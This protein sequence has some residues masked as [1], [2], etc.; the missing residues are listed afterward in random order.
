[1]IKGQGSAIRFYNSSKSADDF[2]KLSILS[3]SFENVTASNASGSAIDV[4]INSEI[5][6]DDS[7]FNNNGKTGRAISQSLNYRSATNHSGKME[8]NNSSFKNFVTSDSGGAVAVNYTEVD[9][10]VT[11]NG[12]TF[13]GNKTTTPGGPGGA[14]QVRNHSKSK[15]VNLMI[16]GTQFNDNVSELSQGGA[17]YADELSNVSFSDVQ[18]SNNA[19]HTQGGAVVM[20]N[21]WDTIKGTF[22]VT[23]TNNSFIGNKVT[24]EESLS[25]VGGAMLIVGA[26]D[27]DIENTLFES[28]SSGADGGAI[29]V[30]GNSGPEGIYLFN[31]SNSQFKK[32]SSSTAQG[33]ALSIQG[34]L[35]AQISNVEFS[36]NSAI[37]G[38]AIFV[39]QP[40]DK[41]DNPKLTVTN[42]QF[43][44][45]TATMYDGGAVSLQTYYNYDATF[46]NNTFD[47]NTADKGEG[48]AIFSWLI[49]KSTSEIVKQNITVSGSTL[50]KNIA[51]QG[52]VIS[53]VVYN[54]EVEANKNHAIDIT[55][56]DS[57]ISD[58]TSNTYGG[59]IF[60]HNNASLQASNNAFSKNTAKESGGAVQFQSTPDFENS[61]N[62]SDS[63]FESNKAGKNGGSISIDVNGDITA[64]TKDADYNKYFA[65]TVITRT[66]FTDN[67]AGNGAFI[68]DAEKYPLLAELAKTNLTDIDSLSSPFLVSHNVAYN[69]HDIN[70]MSDKVVKDVTV[71]YESNGGSTV[72]DETVAYNSVFTKP[73]NPTLADHTF[74]GWFIDN[75]LTKAYDFNTPATKDI[76]LYAKWGKIPAD[77]DSGDPT[78]G[79]KTPSKP[80]LKKVLP[81][82]GEQNTINFTLVGFVLLVTVGIFYWYKRKRT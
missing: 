10:N 81:K 47:S 78:T 8:I 42:S 27:T 70:F 14:L 22:K 21:L 26:I 33:G 15:T 1:M 77:P 20:A 54:K 35:D 52:G 66:S 49:P 60:V 55:V 82:T 73:E 68:L 58:N 76:T 44:S 59:G 30:S 2:V 13:E 61:M 19:A 53:T 24:D 25:A 50:Q 79:T 51:N 67:T 5:K 11:I 31:V 36:E 62:I 45:N 72:P 71:K 46:E 43:N 3:S 57:I 40:S 7:T 80:A 28:N 69:N 9:G 18:F 6:V 56:N 74:E 39:F 23:G 41:A 16:S 34:K 32:N 65:S 48:G 75:E 12:S 63:K 17:I 37:S 4:L 64:S 38:G 29:D